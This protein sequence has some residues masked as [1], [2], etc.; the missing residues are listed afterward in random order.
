MHSVTDRCTDKR[1][2]KQTILSCQYTTKYRSTNGEKTNR[3]SFRVSNR[4]VNLLSDLKRECHNINK[5]PKTINDDD[6]DDDDDLLEI[7]TEIKCRVSTSAS[8]VTT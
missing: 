3:R 2:D 5:H 8:E 7:K 4:G 6:D 1:A